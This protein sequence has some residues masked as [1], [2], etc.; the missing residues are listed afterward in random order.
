MDANAISPKV[1]ATYRQLID[2]LV[3]AGP[4]GIRLLGSRQQVLDQ[5]R[6]YLPHLTEREFQ[7]Y[8]APDERQLLALPPAFRLDVVNVLA[9]TMMGEDCV[10]RHVE[11][12]V[13]KSDG[14]TFCDGQAV[15][16]CDAAIVYGKRLGVQDPSHCRSMLRINFIVPGLGGE[17]LD[18]VLAFV[19][20]MVF[21]EAWDT[22][23]VNRVM[24]GLDASSNVLRHAFASAAIAREFK[25]IEAACLFYCA[26]C[27]TQLTSTRC[28]GC[29]AKL[30]N[31]GQNNE[32][33]LPLHPLV[34]QRLREGGIEFP[35]RA[36]EG[37]DA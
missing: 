34:V 6:R 33:M 32:L 14:P 18:F 28:G 21:T 19:G 24:R 26:L 20:G 10:L 15:L 22:P 9:C 25:D 11:T 3:I 37:P 17:R 2:E 16:F 36:S 35:I 30:G 8:I 29:S 27:G 7:I 5:L 23:G 1:A 31:Y 12:I 13:P 4:Y